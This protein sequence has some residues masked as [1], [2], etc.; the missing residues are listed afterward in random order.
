M[1]S[2]RHWLTLTA[3]L[4]AER[5]RAD[6]APLS[7]REL[8]IPGAGRFGQKCLLLRPTR[9]PD[10]VALPLLVLFHGLGETGSEALGIHAWYD[11]YG[12]PEA[13]ARLCAPPVVRT[14]PRQRYLSDERLAEINRELAL[15]PFP[16]IALVC[17]FTPNV[18]GKDPS[19]P[20]LDRYA[21]YVEHALLPAVRAATPT[22]EGAAQLG[23][24]GV[25]LG[26]Y[27]SLEVFS[28][29]P[30]LFGVVGSMQGAF[31]SQLADVYARR[32][33]DASARLGPR[34][35]HVTT[36]SFDPFRDAA[37][38]LAQRLSELGVDSTFTLGDG[39]HDQTFLREAGT[40]ELLLF[41]ARALHG[42]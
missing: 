29:K 25:S 12:L 17:P 7:V 33:A 23:V 22:L 6:D 27:V 9:V 32:I 35:V 5:A 40:L 41:Q 18:L 39:P 28:R 19:S 3:T 34:R 30:E 16:D 26:G 37:K 8:P 10:S 4:F 24:D 38:R 21:E 15:S 1:L 2:R 42:A 14:L 36:S 31:G 13:Y 11:R 20:V